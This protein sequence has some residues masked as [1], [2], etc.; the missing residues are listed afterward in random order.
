LDQFKQGDYVTI[1]SGIFLYRPNILG[2][3]SSSV[4]TCGCYEVQLLIGRCK[5][6][7]H[8]SK[9]FLYRSEMLAVPEDEA[10]LLLLASIGDKC[11]KHR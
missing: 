1:R 2:Q 6:F 9:M 4:V 7:D 8:L 11:V 10:C 5:H 3:V